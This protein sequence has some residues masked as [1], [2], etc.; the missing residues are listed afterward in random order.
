MNQGYEALRTRVAWLDLRARGRIVARGRDR[1]RF[2]HNVTS[3]EVKTMTP[4]AV[5]YAFLLTPQGRIQA[6]L[7]LVCYED[8]FLIDTLPELREKVRTHILKYKVADQVELEDVTESTAAIGVEGPEAA[9]VG[10]GGYPITE[11]GQPGY[12]IYCAASEMDA[13]V[14]GLAAPQASEEEARVVRIENGKPRFGEDIRETSLVQETQ[15]MHA[16]SFTKGCYLGQE[17]VERVRA[18]GHV[19]KKLVRLEIDAGEV[20]PAGTKLTADGAEV[21]EVTSSVVSPRSGKVAAMA[22]VRTPKSDAGTVL[23]AGPAKGIILLG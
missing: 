3:N 14:A 8:H 20:I 1:A 2:L 6:D 22:Y 17:I 10:P 19:N 21:G 16:V 12:R 15:Q 11:T 23:D 18:Q 5:A 9:G 4:G 13:I 7:W